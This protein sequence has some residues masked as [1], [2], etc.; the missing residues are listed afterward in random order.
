MFIA[1]GICLNMGLGVVR[2]NNNAFWYGYRLIGPEGSIPGQ[3]KPKTLKNG[4]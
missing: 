3:V 4:A 1:L 2:T